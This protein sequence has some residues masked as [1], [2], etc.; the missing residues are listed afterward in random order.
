MVY[1]L[2]SD[3]ILVKLLRA[4]DEEALRNI[5]LRYWKTLYLCVLKKVRAG[6]IAEELVQNVFVSLWEKRRESSI[7]MLGPYLQTAVKFQAINYIKSNI[8]HKSII[9]SLAAN[10]K[11]EEN[12]SASALLT[13]ELTEAIDH[14][15]RLLPEKTQLVFR[16][17]RMENRSNSE[18]SQSL[19]I[20]EK[21]V[22]YHITQSLR[23]LRFELKE[24]MF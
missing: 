10:T 9:D 17:S 8:L 12:T 4:D 3:D 20:S 19:H 22:E 13:R 23:L 24:F 21:A 1:D 16:L 15:I 5:Y 7:R 14:G 2:L 11:N 6:N 18:I